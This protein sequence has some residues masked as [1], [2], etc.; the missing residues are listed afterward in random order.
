MIVR[1][2]CPQGGVLSPLLWNIVINFLLSRLNN[3]SL[4]AQGLANNIAIVINGKLLTKVCELMQKALFIVHTWCR[5][6]GLSANADKAS[7][8]LF[9]SNRK[10]GGFKKSIIF[11]TELQLKNPVKYLGDKKLN[12]NIHI[13]HRIQKANIAFWQCLRAMGK[14]W[15]LKPKVVYWIYT[16]LEEKSVTNKCQSKHNTPATPCLCKH[17]REHA[18]YSNCRSGGHTDVATSW[19]LY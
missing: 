7:M 1:R 17:N 15:G 10:L 11:G 6:V 5:E 19:Y 16:W 2:A 4:W 9:T 12:W 3:E 18:F 13:Y 14:T 8:V